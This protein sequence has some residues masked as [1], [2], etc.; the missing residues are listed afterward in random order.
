VTR[1]VR[2]SRREAE[3][4]AI[5][6]GDDRLITHQSS[7]SILVYELVE[8]LAWAAGIAELMQMAKPPRG[9]VP[10]FAREQDVWQDSFAWVA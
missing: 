6:S 3:A 4:M 5:R 9:P 8:P 2:G 7:L 1:T 10:T